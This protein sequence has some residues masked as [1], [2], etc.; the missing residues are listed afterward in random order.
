MSETM[1]WQIDAALYCGARDELKTKHYCSDTLL[2]DLEKRQQMGM[3][4][5]WGWQDREGE[6]DSDIALAFGYAYGLHAAEY[7][8]EQS[9]MMRSVQDAWRRWSETGV[10]S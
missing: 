3:A 5:V 7:M 4:Y 1:N 8:L 2:G 6:C 9:C 10:I